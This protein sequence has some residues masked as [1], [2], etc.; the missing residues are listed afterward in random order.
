MKY[1]E[2]ASLSDLGWAEWQANEFALSLIMPIASASQVVRDVQRELGIVRNVGVIFL[3]H[4]AQNQVDC[5][6][7][8]SRLRQEYQITEV[9]LRRRLRYLGILKDWRPARRRAQLRQLGSLFCSDE[10]S[11]C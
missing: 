11:V 6:L 3:D 10:E 8:L 4:Q 5:A 9:M 2:M 1:R 7:I